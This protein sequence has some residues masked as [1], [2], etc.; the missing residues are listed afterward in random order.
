[1]QKKVL[2][3]YFDY[4]SGFAYFAW[5]EL[6]ELRRDYDIEVMI[7]PVVFGALLD[8]WGQLGPAEIPSK[9]SFV[10]SI[11]YFLPL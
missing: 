2:H 5:Y 10:F 4:L 3:F 6:K 9:K 11:V 8:H 7:H 1:M